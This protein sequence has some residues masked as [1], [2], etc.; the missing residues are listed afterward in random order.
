LEK[1]P[2]KYKEMV[3]KLVEGITRELGSAAL[4]FELAAFLTSGQ[5]P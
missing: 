3:E 5:K 1:D 2:E 4:K